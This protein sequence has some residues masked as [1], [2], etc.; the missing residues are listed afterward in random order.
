MIRE[1]PREYQTEQIGYCKFKGVWG[2]G[3]RE[4]VGQEDVS[5]DR[6]V[7]L[8]AFNDAPRETRLRCIEK[9][10]ELVDRLARAALHTTELMAKKLAETKAFV[11]AINVLA[12]AA[13]TNEILPKISGAKK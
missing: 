12:P 3:I 6:S 10:P 2:L 8:W 1:D 13:E 7:N 5:E 11:S 4:A 9:L